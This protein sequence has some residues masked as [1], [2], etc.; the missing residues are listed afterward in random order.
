MIINKKGQEW[1]V[2]KIYPNFYLCVNRFGIRECFLKFE[3]DGVPKLVLEKQEDLYRGQQWQN[4]ING[5][6]AEVV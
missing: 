3:V 5:Q 2:K 1:L 4:Y 6:Y